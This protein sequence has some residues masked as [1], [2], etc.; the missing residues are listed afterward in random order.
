MG[1][2]LRAVLWA[3]SLPEPPTYLHPPAPPGS[4]LTRPGKSLRFLRALLFVN[5]SVWPCWQNNSREKGGWGLSHP[6]E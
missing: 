4:R 6:E 3:G 1:R 5:R 2:Q